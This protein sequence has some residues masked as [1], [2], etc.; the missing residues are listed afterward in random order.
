MWLFD[1]FNFWG[2]N[3]HLYGSATFLKGRAKRKLLNTKNSGLVIDGEKRI[4]EKNSFKHL[5]LVAPTGSGKTTGYIIPNILNLTSSAVVTDPSGEIYK[6]TSGYL[7]S[8]GFKIKVLNL[9]DVQSSLKYNPLF[10]ANDFTEIKKVSDVLISSAF[11]SSEAETVF[12]NDG[13]KGILN[14]LIRCL[15]KEPRKFQNLHNLRFLLNSFGSSGKNLENFIAKNC[16]E[17][18]PTLNEWK[19]IISNDEKVLQGYLATAKTSLDKFSDPT[20]CKLSSSETLNF[21]SLRTEKTIIY[22]IV[23]EHEIKY[24]SFFLTLLYTQIFSFA[25]D[26][27]KE[28]QNYL[29]IYFLLDEFGNLGALPNFSNLI[30]TLRKRKVSCSL[31]LQDQEQLTNVYGRA[32]AS[33]ILNGG[34]ANRIYFSGLSQNTCEELERILGKYTVSF[35]EESFHALG[36]VTDKAKDRQIG[37]SLLTADEI[38]TMKDNQA[39]F[40]HSNLRPVMLNV[41]PF[42]QN[43]KL[44][45]RTEIEAPEISNEKEKE[46]FLEYLRL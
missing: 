36:T 28:N 39:I 2:R 1:F 19:G 34:C 18:E 24:Y 21:E 14:V 17:D 20:L 35:M 29:P 41:K 32:E 37:R 25:M 11:P 10:R 12:W 45:R 40:I 43:R 33:T 3:K 26:L 27:P 44:L 9:R 38:R 16:F 31:V 6:K 42:Y 8:Q 7:K 22:I 5:C 30:T 46:S 15:K 4:T 23:P 13:A